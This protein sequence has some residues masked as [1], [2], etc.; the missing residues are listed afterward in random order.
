MPEIES[1]ATFVGA[2]ILVSV[3]GLLAMGVVAPSSLSVAVVGGVWLVA[4]GIGLRVQFG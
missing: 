2:G 4:S 1:D 3:G